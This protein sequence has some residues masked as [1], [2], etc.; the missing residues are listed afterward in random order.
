MGAGPDTPTVRRRAGH[1]ASKESG[2]RRRRGW[3]FEAIRVSY[4]LEYPP[5]RRE[6]FVNGFIAGFIGGWSKGIVNASAERRARLGWEAV[7]PKETVVV[8]ETLSERK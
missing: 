8:S 1:W 5:E 3:K 7:A 4:E 2:S 6:R